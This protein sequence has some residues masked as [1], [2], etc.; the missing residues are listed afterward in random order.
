MRTFDAA[1]AASS[2]PTRSDRVCILQAREAR[3][4]AMKSDLLCRAYSMSRLQCLIPGLVKNTR[5]G[6]ITAFPRCKLPRNGVFPDLQ[7]YSSPPLVS[8]L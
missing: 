5:V 8:K 7:R 6:F 2:D 3:E 4:L 1:F